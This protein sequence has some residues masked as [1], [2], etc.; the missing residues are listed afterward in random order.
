MNESREAN[1]K[2]KDRS[3]V[4]P[5]LSTYWAVGRLSP[6]GGWAGQPQRNPSTPTSIGRGRPHWAAAVGWR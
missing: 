1:F 5:G 3:S 4:K 6:I 2:N